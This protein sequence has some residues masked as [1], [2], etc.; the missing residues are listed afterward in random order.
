MAYTVNKSDQTV[1]AIVR[2]YDK[3]DMAGIVLPGYGLINYGEVMAENLIRMVE[4]FSAPTA[5]KTPIKGQF[6]FDTQNKA[7]KVYMPEQTPQWVIVFRISGGANVSIAH[8]STA[9]YA[10]EAGNANTLQN[11]SPSN[12][13]TANTVATRDANGDLTARRFIGKADSATR[14]D[15]AASADVATRATTADSATRANTADSAT[16]AGRATNADNANYASRAG[17]ADTATSATTATTAGTANYATSAGSAN[18]ATN[19]TNATNANY[20]T[21][22]GSANTATTATNANHATTAGSATNA[23]YA[24]SSGNSDTVDGYH[25]SDLLNRSNHTGALPSSAVFSAQYNSGASGYVVFNNGFMVQWGTQFISGNGYATVSYPVAF[26]SHSVCVVSAAS[27]TGDNAKDNW[28]AT[29]IST[30][31][32]AQ[33]KQ[34]ADEGTTF[35]WVAMGY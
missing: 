3:V 13:A 4:N 28:P 15:S 10:T 27:S 9:D 14:A 29:R 35:Q 23:N 7:M 8:A 2:D 11:K 30:R 6:W 1:A 20:A 25:A 24:N 31:T 21:S 18:T 22:A 33:V 34:A 5:P 26:N 12:S 17:S 16:T 32:Y 19:A